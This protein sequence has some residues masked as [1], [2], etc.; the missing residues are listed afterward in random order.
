MRVRSGVY[1]LVLDVDGQSVAD[2][3]QQ[4][5]EALSIAPTAVAVVNG[6]IVPDSYVLRQVDQLEFVRPAGRKGAS[7]RATDSAT[8]YAITPSCRRRWI[9]SSDRPR[10]PPK[11]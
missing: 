2:V 1:E 8:S 9:S 4:L 3:R 6:E 11:T 5:G 10:S 7:S